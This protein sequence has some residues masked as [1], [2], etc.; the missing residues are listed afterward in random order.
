MRERKRTSSKRSQRFLASHKQ[1][2]R[3]EAN[4]ARIIDC[5]IGLRALGGPIAHTHTHASFHTAHNEKICLRGIPN[6]SPNRCRRRLFRINTYFLIETSSY[7]QK[8]KA[9]LHTR[10]K[11]Q[12]MF[13][14][15]SRI[16]KLRF[17]HRVNEDGDDGE[18]AQH[19]FKTF[20]CF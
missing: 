20:A 11:S 8:K 19:F 18:H 4:Y 14:N 5:V 3:S 10:P 15:E 6:L 9:L 13:E 7:S 16:T 1:H 12:Q 2:Q 17:R